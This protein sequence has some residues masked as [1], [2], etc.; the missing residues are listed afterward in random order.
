MEAQA[1]WPRMKG[2]SRA[3]RKGRAGPQ[4]QVSFRTTSLGRPIPMALGS[5]TPR[6]A[7]GSLPDIP[8]HSLLTDL[9]LDPRQLFLTWFSKLCPHSLPLPNSIP[10]DNQVRI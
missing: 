7:L 9:Q 6:K 1:G 8:L 2:M 3:Q 10:A 4:L 5:W